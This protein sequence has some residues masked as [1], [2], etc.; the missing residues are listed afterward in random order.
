MTTEK[1]AEMANLETITR[2]TMSGDISIP[3]AETSNNRNDDKDL[4]E[5]V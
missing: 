4:F 2:V 1:E 3:D 5:F